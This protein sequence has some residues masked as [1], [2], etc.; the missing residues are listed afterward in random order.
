MTL[1]QPI[2]L[3]DSLP[4]EVLI[5]DTGKQNIVA[6]MRYEMAKRCAEK[7]DILNWGLMMFPEKFVLSFC[8]ELH[9]YFI[10]IRQ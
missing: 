1:A 5:A 6:N 4:L 7:K 10:Q 8:E 2:P 9:G 3:P